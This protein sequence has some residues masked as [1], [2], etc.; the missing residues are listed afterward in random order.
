MVTNFAADLK[1][2]VVYVH[3]LAAVDPDGVASTAIL[4]PSLIGTVAEPGA[5]GRH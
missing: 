3:L 4:K 1:S 2:G 5:H